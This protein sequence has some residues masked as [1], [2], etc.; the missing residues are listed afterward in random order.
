MA[1]DT[2]G[3]VFAIA[4]NHFCRILLYDMQ[5]F[6]K[7]PFL[8]IH[9]DDPTLARVTFPP[10]IPFMTTLSFSSNGKF[11]LVGTSTNAHY[12]IDSF[13]GLLVAK[14]VGH[15]G[16]ERGKFGKD[17]APQPIK[18]ISGDE[19]CWTPDS[20]FV[21]GG[22]QD[23]KILVWD[24][25]GLL[26]GSGEAKG[27]PKGTDP[28]IL[29]PVHTLEGHPGPSRCV[30]FNP[31][32]A[33]LASAGAEMVRFVAAFYDEL[34][35]TTVCRL[36]GYL[37]K[38]AKGKKVKLKG[39]KGPCNDNSR[40]ISPV[41]ICITDYYHGPSKSVVRLWT[42]KF[43]TYHTTRFSHRVSL[44]VARQFKSQYGMAHLRHLYLPQYPQTEHK[45]RGGTGGGGATAVKYVGVLGGRLAIPYIPRV[46][47][48]TTVLRQTYRLINELL[49]VLLVQ[50]RSANI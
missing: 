21:V 50:E 24:C 8:T 25:S 27:V 46:T 32:W 28:P 4:L 5:N 48:R 14:L 49:H 41:S 39:R 43:T 6:D 12:I 13:E 7:D 31:R 47:C 1:Y 22:S 23:G 34:M 36:F 29:E 10:R 44:C 45:A 19:V 18:G 11:I 26:D 42:C 9:L 17:T 30:K 16:L 20:K 33:M 15:V 37:I 40:S 2:S 35:L 3:L 38:P